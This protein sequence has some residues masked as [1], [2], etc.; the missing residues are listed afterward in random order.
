MGELATINEFIAQ[1]RAVRSAGALRDLT[2]QMAQDIGFDY[3]S[4]T[5]VDYSNPDQPVEHIRINTYPEGWVD[6]IVTQR[7][8]RDDPAYLASCKTAVGFRHADIP[9]MIS[10]SARHHHILEQARRAG[11]GDGFTVPAHI[12]GESNGIAAFVVKTGRALPEAR[13]PMAQLVGAFAYEAARRLREEQHGSSRGPVQLTQRQL[14]C[15]VQVARGKTDWEISKILGIREETV[16]DHIDEARR[17]YDVARRTQ[18][19]VRA[20]FDGHFTLTD[21]LI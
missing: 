2:A 8:F 9:S 12:P 6:Q 18:V 3:F 11:V 13:L 16:S 5:Q 4:L 14:D 10:M 20:L 21:A 1:S 19:V 15:I 17:R 7:F